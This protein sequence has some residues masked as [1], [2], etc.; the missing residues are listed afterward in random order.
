MKYA[1]G[2][3][4]D[5]GGDNMRVVTFGVKLLAYDEHVTPE[6]LK[7]MV[8]TLMKSESQ[9]DIVSPGCEVLQVS[10]GEIECLEDKEN[11]K[12]EEMV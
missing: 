7:G 12:I 5:K 11:L 8:E 3:V 10:I 9:F 4:L 1:R 6:S 2:R